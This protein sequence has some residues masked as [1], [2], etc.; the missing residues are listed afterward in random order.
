MMR[1]RNLCKMFDVASIVE[2]QSQVSGKF[3]ASSENIYSDGHVHQRINSEGYIE[4]TKIDGNPNY[5][6]FL[7]RNG[8]I[9]IQIYKYT[10]DT[11]Y[12]RI[13][14]DLNK[15]CDELGVY[16]EH[17]DISQI[18][19]N[20]DP[21]TNQNQVH[22]QTQH[23]GPSLTLPDSLKSRV[24]DINTF[25]CPDCNIGISYRKI[26]NSD[27]IIGFCSKCFV[28]YTLM[29]SRFY[30]IKSKKVNYPAIKESRNFTIEE[31]K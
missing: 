21:K 2:K 10:P 9:F 29:P 5:V 20:I 18:T 12:K 13:I 26:P 11:L 16:H 30:V 15:L 22:H 1:L 6:I 27:A 17:V 28:E 25:K 19:A 24:I 23:D 4:I 31:G 14:D 3:T 7:D 8:E